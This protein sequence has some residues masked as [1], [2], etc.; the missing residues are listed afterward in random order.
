MSNIQSFL[1]S[2]RFGSLN[3]N[4][5]KIVLSS[6]SSKVKKCSIQPDAS[7]LKS[8]STAF[9]GSF[10][11][12]L[13]SLCLISFNTHH[14]LL[15]SCSTSCLRFDKRLQAIISLAGISL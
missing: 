1:E 7:Y 13:I 15:I 4:N 5:E 6:G 8:L 10:H 12:H 9:L 11:F 14:L 2:S 3:L